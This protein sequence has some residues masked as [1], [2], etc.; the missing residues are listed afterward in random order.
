MKPTEEAQAKYN[1]KMAYHKLSDKVQTNFT[2]DD[3]ILTLTYDD[4]HLPEDVAG[5]LRKFAAFVR[6]LKRR[7][8]RKAPGSSAD[9]KYINIIQQGSKGGR[10]HHHVFLKASNLSFEEIREAWGQGHTDLKHLEYNEEGLDGLVE[11]VLEGRASVKR[12]TCSQNL[13][14][15]AVKDYGPYAMSAAD[16]MHI[17]EHPEDRDWIERRFPGWK[18]SRVDA[19]PGVKDRLGLFVVVYF[20]REDNAYFRRTRYGMMDYSYRPRRDGN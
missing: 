5:A 12:W 9:L 13:N 14:E 11:Y 7:M 15:P 20:Y 10:L 6:R 8:E 18:V 3:W 17:N 19:R 4:A 16:V 1:A 2:P